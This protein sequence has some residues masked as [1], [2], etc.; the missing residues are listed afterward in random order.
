MFT[1]E[2]EITS[3]SL[4]AST[5]ADVFA[6]DSYNLASGTFNNEYANALYVDYYRH[7]WLIQL[8][9]FFGIPNQF[10]VNEKITGKKILT[11][12]FDWQ[13]GKTR[14]RKSINFTLAPFM[15]LKNLALII[16]V[17]TQNTFKLFTE[18]L[19]ALAA[20]GLK[21]LVYATL[22][23]CE[24][25]IKRI[26]KS[27]INFFSKLAKI[28]GQGLFM[29]P[30]LLTVGAA[31]LFK[32][33]ECIGRT[34]TSPVNSVGIAYFYCVN[35]DKTPGKFVGR[36]LGCV[37][38]I[39][40]MASTAAIWSLLFPFILAAAPASIASALTGIMNAFSW[41]NP[42]FNFLGSNIITLL[43]KSGVT[44]SQLSPLT[45]GFTI[46]FSVLLTT[47]GPLANN[48]FY[49][50]RWKWQ[51]TGERGFLSNTEKQDRADLLNNKT[52]AAYIHD[53]MQ[54][55]GQQAKNIN[56]Q[57]NEASKDISQTIETEDKKA[58]KA[59]G[60]EERKAKK[61][62]NLD[63]KKRK[64]KKAAAH[65]KKEVKEEGRKMKRSG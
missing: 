43:T 61:V 4:L 35:K 62:V 7:H 33:I 2:E 38:A 34:V 50:C 24:Q 22:R 17:T 14:R 8:T 5:F 1:R 63:G 29:I 23:N 44:L 15:L 48:V 57:V 49:W 59:A 65:A 32:L 3:H 6:G 16:L 11:N 12:L 37:L 19:P 52:S 20:K 46:F 9:S 36:L 64:V 54:Q 27:K 31:A 25:N 55:T 13:T 45:T 21:R 51:T 53:I 39:L 42:A 18:F 10:S 41:M 58:R 60:R 28:A 30:L 56:Q 47:L 26:W 40:S